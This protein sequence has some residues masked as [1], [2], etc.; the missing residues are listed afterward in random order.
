MRD[1]PLGSPSFHLASWFPWPLLDSDSLASERRQ[2]QDWGTCSSSDQSLLPHSH[3]LSGTRELGPPR[4]PSQRSHPRCRELECENH[5]SPSQSTLLARYHLKPPPPEG[6]PYQDS[7]PAPPDHRPWRRA[8]RPEP[9][10][11]WPSPQPSSRGYKGQLETLG[12]A[13][14]T[15]DTHRLGHGGGKSGGVGEVWLGAVGQR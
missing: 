1:P 14:P 5:N 13:A 15:P 12:P 7:T 4:K 10:G 9:A 3:G 8:R 6:A 11:S 2:F